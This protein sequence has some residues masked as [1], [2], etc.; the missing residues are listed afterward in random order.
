MESRITLRT[1]EDLAECAYDEL[2]ELTEELYDSVKFHV[3]EL[4]KMGYLICAY[5]LHLRMT[6][7]RKSCKYTSPIKKGHLCASIPKK[8]KRLLLLKC[9]HYPRVSFDSV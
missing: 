2:D 3:S 1:L 7:R 6:Y 5:N 8:V 4:V 9:S